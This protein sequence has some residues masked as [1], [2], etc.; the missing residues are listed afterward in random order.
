MRFSRL[1]AKLG[2]PHYRF[3]DLRHAAASIAMSIGVPNTYTQKRMGHKTD[4]MLKTVYLHTIR[5]ME[6]H[7][8]DAIDQEFT[9][10]L[11]MN[12]QTEKPET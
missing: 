12:L 7:Y 5:S 9:K 11:Q 3:H 8:A 6:D 1:C 2:L 4:N 10:I